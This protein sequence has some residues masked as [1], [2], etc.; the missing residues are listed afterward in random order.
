MCSAKEIAPFEKICGIA[1][2]III[3]VKQGPPYIIM[4]LMSIA[5]LD[6][7]QALGH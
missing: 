6:I 5:D 4:Y 2:Y 3:K 1:K 7:F